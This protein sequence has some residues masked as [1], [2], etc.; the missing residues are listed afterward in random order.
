MKDSERIS[1]NISPEKGM[2][3]PQRVSKQITPTRS[4]LRK[5]SNHIKLEE[6][7]SQN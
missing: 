3:V 6:V 4:H 7:K 1:E 5:L 2:E